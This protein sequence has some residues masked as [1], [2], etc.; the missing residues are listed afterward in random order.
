MTEENEIQ[1]GVMVT[2]VRLDDQ[3][4]WYS[5]KSQRACRFYKLL[6][7]I[8]IFIS[9]LIPLFSVFLNSEAQKIMAVLGVLILLIEGIQQ[10]NQYQ[11][12]WLS[13]RSICESLKKEKYTFLARSSCY[14]AIENPDKLL[15]E[16]IEN[17]IS[18]ENSRWFSLQLQTRVQDQNKSPELEKT[19]S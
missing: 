18:Q 19:Q 4:A 12:I 13:Y 3:I 11:Q 1:E 9:A 17:L 5:K 15:S 7:F 14:S 16:R 10:L 6:K 8:Q 2:L